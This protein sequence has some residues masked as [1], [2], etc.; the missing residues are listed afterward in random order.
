VIH[1]ISVRVMVAVLAVSLATPVFAA[2]WRSIPADSSLEFVVTFEG[3]ESTGKFEIFSA[4]LG[5]EAESIG[6][7]S[8]RVIVDV[9]SATM[10]SADLDEAI[11][12]KTWFDSAAYPEASFNS[13]V[14][15]QTEKQEFLA[16][17]EVSIKGVVRELDLPLNISIEGDRMELSGKATLS[18]MD[19][20]IGTGEWE[21]DSSI[22]HAVDVRFKLLMQKAD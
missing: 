5:F 9:R 15:H 11:S 20:G 22:A 3:A 14:M 2:K 19:F 10:S 7:S 6:T 17:G 8:L 4:E 21:S 18:R 16:Q 13:T 12:E 1:P